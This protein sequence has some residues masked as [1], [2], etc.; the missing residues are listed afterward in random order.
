MPRPLTYL[1]RILQ[2]EDPSVYASC[3]CLQP[4]KMKTFDSLTGKFVDSVVDC[5]KCFNCTNQHR[6]EWVTRMTLHSLYWQYCYFVTL[7]YGSYNLNPY[8]N[9]PFKA[10]WLDTFP[11]LDSY[12]SF[13]A[14]RWTPSLIIHE[15]LTKYLKRLRSRLEDNPI[16]YAACGELGS[17]YGRP[18][19]HLIVW[20]RHPISTAEFRE[21][22]SY[23][24]V[25]TGDPLDI[26]A[27]RGQNVTPFS[28]C[29]G[30]VDVVDLVANG[31]LNLQQDYPG[32]DKVSARKCFAYVA[33]Y[34]GKNKDISGYAY[35]RYRQA[36]I[37]SPLDDNDPRLDSNKIPLEN[38]HGSY[39]CYKD[40]DPLDF[41]E[42]CYHKIYN[43]GLL[44]EKVD[45]AKFKRIYSPFFVASRQYVLGKDYL[46]ENL[47]RFT[48]GN[49]LLPQ[50][51]GKNF[52]FPTYYRRAVAYSKYPLRLRKANDSGISFV[53]YH[54]PTVA[55][56]YGMLREDSSVYWYIADLLRR[57][58][59]RGREFGAK[60][61]HTNN[62]ENRAIEKF[63]YDVE[64]IHP[65]HGYM[66]YV[67]YPTLEYFVGFKYDRITREY[68]RSEIVDRIDFCDWVLDIIAKQ[69]RLSPELTRKREQSLDL[70]KR[71]EDAPLTPHVREQYMALRNNAQ[72]KYNSKHN[73]LN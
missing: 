72:E 73:D 4:I 63:L 51:Q 44:Y 20:S 30:N 61:F 3:G 2:G 9:H 45:F 16:S 60:P 56:F 58:K 22:W 29:I 64:I 55:E 39:E 26:R 28:F 35:D 19:F 14:P 37:M 8:K 12:N 40:K 57:D 24:C 41:V 52:T 13:H 25:K 50:L 62:I 71:I 6:N 7:T 66:T 42:S 54:L 5:G 53:K 1:H 18:H 33:K 32:S 15:H 46:L 69:V 49:Y 48:Q 10:D 34:I 43:N 67:Y 68:Y 38:T 17:T 59:V 47:N 27:Y 70:F 36:Y 31:T 11:V 65:V 21:A 23:K